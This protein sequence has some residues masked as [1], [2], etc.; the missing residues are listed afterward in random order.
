MKRVLAV[1]LLAAAT[2]SAR[3]TQ[4]V[5]VV[6]MDGVRYTEGFG[7]P[8]H[9]WIPG[10]WTV[11]RPGGTIYTSCSNDGLTETNPGHASILTGTWQTIS[12]TG[13]ERP[14]SPTVFEY[15]RKQLGTGPEQ[16]YVVLGKTKL[17]IV[18]Y[19]D[20]S[21][22]GS[23]YGA[24]VARCP[25]QYDDRGAADTLKSLLQRYHPRLTMLNFPR[26]DSVA[27]KGDW[28]GYLSSVRVA[29]S[30]AVEIWSAVQGDPVMGGKTTMFVIND[31]G[32][33]TST[34]SSHGD[35]CEGCRHIMLL[36][37]GPDTPAGA[38]D[39]IPCKQVDLAPTVGALLGFT[40]QYSTGTV[41]GSALVNG[42]PPI[43][44]GGPAMYQL[45]QNYPNPFNPATRIGYGLARRGHVLLAV[46][47][48]LGQRVAVL[49]E[50]EREAGN[51]E[52]VFN[53]AG[54]SSG[55]YYYRL[56]AEGFAETKRL[57]L[58]R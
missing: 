24:Y 54:F 40:T 12:N 2:L 42:V 43:A 17:G 14:H 26:A 39:S 58:I 10:I 3:Q 22:Y 48:T 33:H 50:G 53:A 51:H 49:E 25:N 28:G 57:T 44:A 27:H 35:G 15:Y 34:W 38:V 13:G 6:V 52:V 18:S 31:H 56:Q 9:Q 55:V 19:S 32:R 30:L 8:A 16:H 21:D 47:N 36:A 20:W 46:F 45:R 1:L 11:L 23:P 37:I 7:D 29:D 4:F 41:L 5:V